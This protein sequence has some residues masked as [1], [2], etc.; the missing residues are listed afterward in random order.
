MSPLSTINLSE[1]QIKAIRNHLIN[2]ERSIS[3]REKSLLSVMAPFTMLPPARLIDAYHSAAQA[4][5]RYPDGVIVE[6]GVFGGGALFSMAYAAASSYAFVGKVV[7]FDTFEGHTAR[8]L[9]G[10]IDLHGR[11]QSKVF[12]EL[13]GSGEKWAACS[14]EQVEENSRIAQKSL[15]IEFHIDLV[16]GDACFTAS[17]ISQFGEEVSLLRLD[18]D[19]YEPTKAALDS[20]GPLLS[21]N[22]IIIIDDYGHHS[23]VRQAVDDYFLNIRRRFDYSMTDYSCRRIQ[24]LD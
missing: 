14:L 18:M 6:F 2:F 4:V 22:A 16:K 20:V 13:V 19:W 8:P 24:F 9:E 1:Q 11:Q 5:E 21:K 23:G 15:G 7:G 12:D 3:E 17:S 10:E